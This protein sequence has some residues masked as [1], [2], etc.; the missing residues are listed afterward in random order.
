[1]SDRK[2]HWENVYATKNDDEVSWYQENPET[3]LKLIT[4][5]EL[6]NE[7]AI[8]DVG[9]GNSNLIGELQKQAFAN[10]SVLDIA[11]KSL[12][13]TKA[14]LGA[15]AKHIQW[16]VAD[17]LKFKPNQQKSISIEPSGKASWFG[18]V[19]PK[20]II[21]NNDFDWEKLHKD[22]TAKTV[23]YNYSS[24]SYKKILLLC[25][26]IVEN[27]KPTNNYIGNNE[28]TKYKSVSITFWLHPNINYAFNVRGD[29]Q[30]P[31]EIK[32]LLDYINELES[33]VL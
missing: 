17:V 25:K 16:I 31:K 27:E 2:Q 29:E 20:S 33:Q 32:R 15:N 24:E 28:S 3:S 22:S 12:T 7:A 1:M 9:G 8:I 23:E 6:N 11:E 19:S 26:T 4:A 5:L 18:F 21:K 13:R 30:F 14:K 10:L